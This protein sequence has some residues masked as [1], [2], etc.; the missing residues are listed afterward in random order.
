MIIEQLMPSLSPTMTEGAI[1]SWHIKP[2]DQVKPGQVMA[3]I[4]TDK[5]V[6]EWECL[7]GGTVAELL[8]TAG[9]VAKV[10]QIA[11]VF[12]TKGENPAEAIAK[13]KAKNKALDGGAAVSVP[14]ATDK[15]AAAKPVVSAPA[16]SQA[17]PAVSTSAPPKNQTSSQKPVRIS[18]VAARLAAANGIDVRHVKP[19]GPDGRVIRRDIEGAITSGTAKIGAAGAS[20]AKPSKPKLTPFRADRQATTD[21]PISIMRAA[22]AKRLV[23]SKQTIPHFQVTES[24]DVAALVALR[25]QLN[26]YDGF[27]VSVNDLVVRATALALRVHPK[28]NCTYDGTVIRQYDSADISVAVAIPEG[29]IT[30]IVFKAHTLSVSQIGDTVRELAKKALGG[31]LKPAEFEGGTFTISNL[32]MYGIEQFNAIINPPQCAI[33]AVAGIKDEPVVKQGHVV[34]GKIMRVTISCD[35]R[36]IDGAVAAEFLRTLKDFLEAPAGLLV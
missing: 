25:E 34:P 29:L 35:H 13:A 8:F 20:A 24:I 7:D 11:A 28:V 22:I 19:S 5:A 9:S 26:A 2:G 6:V 14:Q 21:I 17:T 4:Q 12:T 16:V 15:P 30:P 18:P 33:L 32:G 3:E 23:S 36:A 31:Q 27:K 1:V 10:N